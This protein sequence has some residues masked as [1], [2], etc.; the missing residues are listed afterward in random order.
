MEASLLIS[1]VKMVSEWL[2]AQKIGF[3]EVNSP[4]CAH[5][6]IREYNSPKVEKR[7]KDALSENDSKSPFC[8][9]SD[10][11]GSDLGQI[12]KKLI[13][14]DEFQQAAMLLDMYAELIKAN[15]IS[16]LLV[17]LLARLKNSEKSFYS[18]LISRTEYVL[19]RNLH[20][21]QLMSIHKELFP[22]CWNA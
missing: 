14:D 20:G 18:N 11:D 22:K 19:E 9:K 6:S 2:W 8:A 7:F 13:K 17:L 5:E 1:L 4:D 3:T 16:S 21:M 10:F 15:E 12:T